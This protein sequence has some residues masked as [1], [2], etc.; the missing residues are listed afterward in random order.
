MRLAE[1]G[2]HVIGV[3]RAKGMLALAR[4]RLP[5]ATVC[6][7]ATRLPFADAS[8]DAVVMVWLLHLLD[9]EQVENAIAEVARVLRPGAALITTVN[10]NDAIYATGSD[11][12]NL[13]APIRARC[14]P[15]QPDAADTIT[16]LANA[17]RMAPVSETTF[18]GHGQGRS[19]R[20]W[21]ETLSTL[22]HDWTRAAD[23]AT[24]SPLLHQLAGLPNQNTP[25]A[26]PVYRLLALQKR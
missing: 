10:K 22:K 9:A 2:R 1:R 18:V 8:Q 6:A 24:I 20:W 15:Q 21:I 16:K 4:T 14:T 13:L 17:H 11:A 25:S 23:Q 5:G 7:D 3:D 26:E 19:P 12:A